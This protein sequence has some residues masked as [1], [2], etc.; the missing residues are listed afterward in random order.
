MVGNSGSVMARDAKARHRSIP[1]VANRWNALKPG[2][3][4]VVQAGLDASGFQVLH[5]AIAGVGVG[6]N[7]HAQMTRALTRIVCEGHDPPVES[8]QG[9]AIDRNELL[10]PGVVAR[11]LAQLAPSQSGVQLVEAIVIAMRDDVV[12]DGMSTV[13][14][15][16][17]TSSCRA[18]GADAGAPRDRPGW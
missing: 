7:H 12:P 14:I 8:R 6:C 4:W 10:P 3:A 13:P 2:Y 11:Q 5:R 16:R 17:E 15:P 9:L 18:I 1:S